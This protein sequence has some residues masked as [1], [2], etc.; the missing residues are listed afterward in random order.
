MKNR[1]RLSKR[2]R[3]IAKFHENNEFAPGK[4]KFSY[5]SDHY[6]DLTVYVSLSYPMPSRTNCM[7]FSRNPKSLLIQHPQ[8]DLKLK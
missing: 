8:K 6:D 4:I 1:L 3:S 7:K 5:N 2:H